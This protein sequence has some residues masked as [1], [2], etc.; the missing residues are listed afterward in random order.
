[1]ARLGQTP[2]SAQEALEMA[3]GPWKE[4]AFRNRKKIEWQQ[5]ALEKYRSLQ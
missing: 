2:L 3:G 1:M 5:W 4:P